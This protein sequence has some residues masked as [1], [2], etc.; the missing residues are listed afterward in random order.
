MSTDAQTAPRVVPPSRRRDKPIVSCSLCRRRKLKCDRQQPCRTCADRGLSL[1]CSYS[2]Q[3]PGPVHEQPK[4]NVHDRIDQ[5]ERLVTSLMETKHNESSVPAISSV[6]DSHEPRQYGSNDQSTDAEIPGTP[7]RVKVGNDTTTYTNSSH[8]TSILDGI[9]EL[10]EHL[11]QIPTS[12]Q[13]R[14]PTIDEI[15]GPDI[16]FGSHKH[17]TKKELLCAIPSRA[18]VDILLET[19][20]ETMHSAPSIIHKPTF[21]REYERFWERPFETP[22]M[23]LGLLFSMLSMATRIQVSLDEY[24]DVHSDPAE[25]SVTLARIDFYREKLVQCLVLANY[26]KCPPYTIETLLQYFIAELFRSQDSQFGTWMIVG[27]VV[28]IAFRM[29]Y[30]REP[31]K[32]SNITPFKAEMRRRIWS[33]VVQLDLMSSSQVGLPRMIQ[34]H[35]YDTR[36][37]H[38]LID[39]DLSEDMTKLPPSR[40]DAEG[41]TVLYANIRTRLLGVFAR[42]MDLSNAPAQPAYCDIMQL[43]ADLRTVYDNIPPLYRIDHIRYFDCSDSDV[44]M[45]KLYLRLNFLRAQLVLHRPYLLLGRTDT[46]YEY[47]RLV[48]LDAAL[49][50]LKFQKILDEESRPGRLFWTAKWRLRSLLWRLSSLVAH[51]F[52]LA[53]TVLCLDLDR[54]LVSPLFV[55]AENIAH[56]EKFKTGPPTRAEIIESLSISY[57]IWMRASER[58]REAQKI[59]ATVDLMLRKANAS[60][61]SPATNPGPSTGHNDFPKIGQQF[62]GDLAP[63]SFVFSGIDDPQFVLPFFESDI[64]MDFGDTFDWGGLE[65]NLAMP[66]Y[67]Q[68]LPYLG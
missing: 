22:V 17:A 65:T 4:T 61:S 64:S 3:A 54:D 9:A 28:R 11:E 35:M 13:P 18:E 43:D 19:Y 26:F 24:T 15:S 38:N 25:T 52:L 68:P 2:R 36:E 51:D 16:I 49:E 34:P 14:N 48:C 39:E 33:M 21:L 27:M 63:S 55:S 66:S 50:S 44:A 8:W 7:D 10:K 47:S 45:R 31:S 30:H 20:F 32:F 53:T 62:N 40:P 57:E 56:R 37:P 58:S 12:P 6:I 59:I 60:V 5:L 42:I 67:E 1:S 41:T 46:R 23:W 29:G